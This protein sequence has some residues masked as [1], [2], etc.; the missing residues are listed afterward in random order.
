MELKGFSA[1]SLSL[2]TASTASNP[3][4]GIESLKY[5]KTYMFTFSG[6]NPFNGIERDYVW[7]ALKLLPIFMNPFN[8]IESLIASETSETFLSTLGIHSM[9]LK[10]KGPAYPRNVFSTAG[11]HS[12]ELKVTSV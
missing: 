3:F 11:I 6:M 9:E 1:T 5:W 10:D 2:L 4:N 7:T 12:M 8:G